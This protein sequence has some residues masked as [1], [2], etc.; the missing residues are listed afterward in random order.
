MVI[1]TII[2]SLLLGK[3]NGGKIRNI[4]N[5]YI[6]G[7]YLFVISFLVEIISLLIVSRTSG[8]LNDIIENNFFYIHIFIYLLLIIGLIMNFHENGFRITLLGAVLNFLP[9]SLN[10]GRMPVALNALKT[11]KLYTQL[12]LLE[13]GRIMTHTLA[14]EFTK[15][16]S[17]GDIIPIPKPYPFPKVISIGDIF[18]S[19]GL[20]ILIQSYMKKRYESEGKTIEFYRP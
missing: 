11:S 14:N 10:N 7:W 4:G 16:V 6:N 17:L 3:L 1:E 18:I 5:L 9:L 19:L 20:L 13:E 2:L 8:N 15:L 12:G